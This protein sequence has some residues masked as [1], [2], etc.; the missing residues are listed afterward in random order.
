MG[1]CADRRDGSLC[2][3]GSIV[4][5]GLMLIAPATAIYA[6][7]TFYVDP[8]RG[9]MNDDGSSDRPWR[10]LQEVF[11]QGK[12]ETFDKNGGIKN[13]GGPVKGGDTIL[14]RSGYHGDVT[15]DGAFNTSYITIAAE[16]G[17]EPKL[18]RLRFR[19]ASKW[20]IRGLTISPSFAFPFERVTLVDIFSRFGYG[21]SSDIVI[22]D[23]FL[24]TVFDS[25]NWTANDW[26]TKA[27]DGIN[28][29][30]EGRDLVARNNHLLNVNFGLHGESTN[31]LIEGN[32][33]EN[34]SGDG[35]RATFHGVTIQYNTIKNCYAV[36]GNHD[37]GIQGYL[38]NVGSGEV[39]DVTI[40]GNIIINRSDPDQPHPGA[41]EGIGCFAGP[42]TRWRVENNVVMTDHWHGITIYRAG[43]CD[44]VN[45]TV[46]NKDFHDGSSDR[47][48]WIQISGG[49]NEATR[50]LI[51]NNIAQSYT[52][53][54]TRTDDHN[55][56]INPGTD[57]EQWF[58]DYQN[59]DLSLIEGSP[60]IDAG[61]GDGAP[62]LDVTKKPRS[63]GHSWDV[64]A[65]EYGVT[66]GST[67]TARHLFYNNSV[68]DGND[69]AANVSDDAAIATD[70]QMLMPNQ[71]ATFVNYSSYSRGINGIMIDI[72][73][74]PGPVDV[75]D[76]EFRVG[77]DDTPGD[78]TTLSSQPEVT[79]RPGQTVGDPDRVTLIWAD[80]VAVKNQWLQV[81]MKANGNT[82]LDVPDVL[83]IGNAIGETGDHLGGD[84]SDANATVDMLDLTGL[85][86]N[87]TGFGAAAD[88]ENHFDFDRNRRVDFFDLLIVRDMAASHGEPLSLIST[89]LATIPDSQEA[90]T[91]ANAPSSASEVTHQRPVRRTL[92]TNSIRRRNGR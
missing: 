85:R 67:V 52:L 44:V 15:Y 62:E 47:F 76:F 83:Y 20:I 53:G 12:I 73:E 2:R 1:F 74:V 25:T 92:R 68:F 46:F 64:G 24:Y 7:N 54:G 8:I 39:R 37:D 69:P 58:T 43:D 82:G 30:M 45:N 72:S 65:Y 13:S 9:S 26:N 61:I 41:M 81:K 3:L 5:A 51:R 27:C 86:R 55:L 19:G 21:E 60:A 91:T 16:E 36:N 90:V 70:K 79:V 32:V 49:V 78:W 80:D 31:A 23:C 89:P 88:V 48:S 56:T 84:G 75:N 14:L 38:A 42:Y 87:T 11:E 50:N 22:E 4:L 59:D 71:Q 57:V 10:T 29:G 63:F 40:R 18:K 33:V 66:T 77:N 6:G 35:A 34:F 28:L 17:Q